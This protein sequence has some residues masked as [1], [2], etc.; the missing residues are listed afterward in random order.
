[1][2]L[3]FMKHN[4]A[5]AEYRGPPKLEIHLT[6]ESFMGTLGP[7]TTAHASLNTELGITNS[8]KDHVESKAGKPIT[9]SSSLRHRPNK[10]T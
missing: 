6:P 3:D 5:A 2:L 9:K 4:A 1:V 10:T 8:R 7:R